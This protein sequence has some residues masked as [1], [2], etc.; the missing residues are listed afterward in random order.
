MWAFQNIEPQTCT[1]SECG[2]VS[3]SARAHYVGTSYDS[4]TKIWSDVSGHGRHVTVAGTDAEIVTDPKSNEI[5]L[6]GTSTTYIEFPTD[7][8]SDTAATSLPY[9]YTFIH[10]CRNIEN[11]VTGRIFDAKTSFTGD[12]AWRN[13]QNYWYSGFNGWAGKKHGIAGHMDC[14]ITPWND[15]I[16]G[17]D[18]VVSVDQV[19]SYRG[20][21]IDFTNDPAACDVYNPTYI[22]PY[23]VTINAG[24]RV[25]WER[26]A[27]ECAEIMAFDYEL[28]IQ[29]VEIMEGCL[30]EKYNT[31]SP[32][33]ASP[34]HDPTAVPSNTPTNTPS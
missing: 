23:V 9:N 17:Y 24:N 32:P 22:S 18:W 16:P 25:N 26:S 33:T 20:N 2:T 27:W 7:L 30:M 6:R 34:T 29:E 3:S 15:N 14:Q 10:V 13:T 21:A 1:V 11:D 12:L 8:L 31:T 28:S 19:T 5:Y 4:S